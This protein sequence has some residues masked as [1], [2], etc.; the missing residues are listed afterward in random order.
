MNTTK[1][2]LSA[3]IKEVEV[4][5]GGTKV[6]RPSIFVATPSIF[7]SLRLKQIYLYCKTIITNVLH[8]DFHVIMILFFGR[9]D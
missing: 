6:V 3:I 5:A 9:S 7:K 4:G 1:K 8:I 2:A